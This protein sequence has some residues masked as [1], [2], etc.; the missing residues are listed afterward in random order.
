M[1]ILNRDL[2]KN[3]IDNLDD[4]SINNFLYKNKIILNKEEYD[5]LK[6]I[7]KEKYNDILDENAYLFKLVKDSINSDAYYKLLE[8]FNKYKVLIKE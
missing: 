1:I 5:F 8:L 6:N 4:N 2:I 3:Y 7:I